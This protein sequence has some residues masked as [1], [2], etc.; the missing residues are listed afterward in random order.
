M[1]KYS[2]GVHTVRAT[3][4]AECHSGKGRPLDLKKTCW[5]SYFPTAKSR[6]QA[7]GRA[8]GEEVLLTRGNLRIVSFEPSGD[9]NTTS[10]DAKD[11]VQ[12]GKPSMYL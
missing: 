5:V 7:N 12:V 11:Q 10:F 9:Q 4:S 2:A 3:R 1:S 6:S 8:K